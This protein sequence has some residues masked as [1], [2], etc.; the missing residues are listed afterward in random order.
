[1]PSACFSGKAGLDFIQ[2]T[3]AFCFAVGKT[4]F[5]FMLVLAYHFCSVTNSGFHVFHNSRI[6]SLTANSMAC[7]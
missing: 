6:N 3:A 1:M 5:G 7:L 4:A 2:P